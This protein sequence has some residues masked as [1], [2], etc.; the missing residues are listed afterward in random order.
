MHKRERD[1]FKYKEVVWCVYSWMVVFLEP[2]EGLEEKNL[3]WRMEVGLR[4]SMS[5]AN[6][7]AAG[8]KGGISGEKLG[9]VF[10][11]LAEQVALYREH[12]LEHG[13]GR[14]VRGVKNLVLL[15]DQFQQILDMA[16]FELTERDED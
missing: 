1:V 2:E 11:V 14:K 8:S 15:G 16:Y 13:H 3:W 7:R 12:G 4:T 6:T 9:Q 10:D 5:E